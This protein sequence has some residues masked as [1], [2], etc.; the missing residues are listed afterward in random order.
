VA[1]V[2]ERL[3]EIVI[4]QLG[5]NEEEVTNEAS[6]QED[7]GAD[8]L[9]VVELVMQIEEEWGLEIPDEDA[10]RIQTF[11]DALNYIEDRVTKE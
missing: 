4:D 9:D 10:E 11:Q 5:V 1:S 2:E 3:R 7:L 6:F 8:S